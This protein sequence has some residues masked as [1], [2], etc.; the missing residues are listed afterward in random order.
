MKHE[1]LK[2]EEKIGKR[3]CVERKR[4]RE[5]R[6]NREYWMKNGEECV[7][8]EKN[9]KDKNKKYKSRRRI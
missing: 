6:G 5:F 3:D 2:M 4:N 9:I 8:C 1:A 7:K